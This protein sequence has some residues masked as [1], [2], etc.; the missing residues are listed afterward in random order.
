MVRR[1]ADRAGG[2][3]CIVRPGTWA[4]KP[5]GKGF[6]HVDAAAQAAVLAVERG[7]P[8]VYNIADDDGALAIDKARHQL[9]FDPDFRV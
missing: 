5:T 2:Q 7:R 4:D 1:D 6:L 3:Q 9:G 8:G